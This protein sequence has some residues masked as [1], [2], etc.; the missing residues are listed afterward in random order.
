MMWAPSLQAARALRVT[1]GEGGNRAAA[2]ARA[3]GQ[4]LL[5]ELMVLA[6]LPPLCGSEG[7]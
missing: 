6:A 2:G 5:G 7:V 4:L 1:G 3:A